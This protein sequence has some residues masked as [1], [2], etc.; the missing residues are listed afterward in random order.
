MPNNKKT[1]SP[2]LLR[3]KRESLNLDVEEVIQ[4]LKDR[5]IE[6]SVKT[7]YGYENGVGTPKVN[8]FIALCDIYGIN[9]IL[10]AFGYRTNISI[11]PNKDDWH[12]SLY[13][14]FF[15]ASLLDKIFILLEHGVPSFNGY[16]DQIEAALPNSSVAANFSRLYTIF[17]SL[18]EAQQ[19]I[20]FHYLDELSAGRDLN[21]QSINEQ[22][23]IYAYRNAS[24]ED[25][26]TINNII[27]RYT[28]SPRQLAARGYSGDA[29]DM[30]NLPPLAGETKESNADF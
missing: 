20:A 11:A 10:G 6:I 1:F 21:S 19:G 5:G 8:T 9:D 29:I 16:E 14:D 12:L 28:Q 18:N 25:L 30:D 4:K 23:L 7:L 2:A 3:Q 22:N 15:N 27:L 13:N 17:S 26:N 24:P